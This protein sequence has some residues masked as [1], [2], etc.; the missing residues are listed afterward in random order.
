M[1][2]NKH[3]LVLGAGISGLAVADFL[4]Q[5]GY[6]LIILEKAAHIAGM[7]AT[8]DYNHFKTENG[9][10]KLYSQIPGIMEYCADILG[11]ECLEVKKKNSIHLLGKTVKFP[12]QLKNLISCISPLTIWTSIKIGLGLGWSICTNFKKPVSYSGYLIKGFGQPFYNLMFKDYALKIWGDP[13]Q[14]SAELARKRIPFANV[15]EILSMILKGNKDKAKSCDYFYYPKMG[16]HVLLDKIAERVK[17]NGGEILTDINV[18]EIS[19]EDNKILYTDKAGN[20]HSMVYDSLISSIN[21]EHL[22]NLISKE[23]LPPSPLKYRSL[24]LVHLIIDKPQAL[25]GD[26]WIFVPE[27]H[28]WF[29]RISEQKQFSP[30]TGPKDQTMVTAEITFDKDDEFFS[31]EDYNAQIGKQVKAQLIRCG[32]LKQDDVVSDILIRRYDNVY[33]IYSLDYRLHLDVLL[34]KV[35]VVPNLYTIG[36]PG[37][38][39]YNNVDLCIHQGELLADHIDKNKSK[40]EWEKLTNYF[41]SYKIID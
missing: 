25:D 40:E 35:K 10:H 32:I 27:K 3:I 24:M 16:F 26:C 7:C 14:L 22:T 36:R 29:N 18:T 37:L 5:Q 12:I 33:P 39:S 19:T 11:D 4:S 23:K 1:K 31:F 6:K 28:Y 8:I 21:L 41:N 38:F 9:P 13:K 15:W 2:S 17:S 34:D 20:L 30:Y